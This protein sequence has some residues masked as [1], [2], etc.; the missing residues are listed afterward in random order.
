MWKIIVGWGRPLM[1][2]WPVR[3]ECWIIKA[4]NTHQ[5]YVIFIAFGLQYWLDERAS[6]L[7]YT[8]GVC[9]SVS[10]VISMS[11]FLYISFS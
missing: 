3:F 11:A 4:T 10:L 7:R 1:T 6:I 2:K 9:L 5:E 8:Y